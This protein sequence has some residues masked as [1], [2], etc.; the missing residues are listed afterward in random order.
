MADNMKL[1]GV[2]VKEI[3]K[4]I[5]IERTA[6]ETADM[7]DKYWAMGWEV[8]CSYMDGRHL[9]LKKREIKE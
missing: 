3:Y 2:F 9:I 4:I 5:T 8:V 1:N 7:L 6:R